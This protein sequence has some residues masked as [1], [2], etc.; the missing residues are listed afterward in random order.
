MA[1]EA[2][3]E[4]ITSLEERLAIQDRNIKDLENHGRTVSIPPTDTA[5]V[6]TISVTYMGFTRSPLPQDIGNLPLPFFGGNYPI[7]LLNNI[8]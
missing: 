2:A 7:V 4:Y 1:S 6:S 8:Y 5:T 3:M